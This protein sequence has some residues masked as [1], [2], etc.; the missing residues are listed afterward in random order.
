MVGAKGLLGVAQVLRTHAAHF[1]SSL[2][3]VEPL[4]VRTLSGGHSLC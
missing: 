2:R 3:S 4:S 1:P